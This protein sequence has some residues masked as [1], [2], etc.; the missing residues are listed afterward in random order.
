MCVCVCVCVVVCV[1]CVCVCVTT[2]YG[3]LNHHT[4][5]HKH[6][7]SRCEYQYVEVPYEATYSCTLY[8][9]YGIMSNHYWCFMEKKKSTKTMSL[10]LTHLTI[11]T[12]M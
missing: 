12:N 4:Y 5:V 10:I 6:T 3:T 1:C 2:Y 11:A 7:G 9:L 8:L